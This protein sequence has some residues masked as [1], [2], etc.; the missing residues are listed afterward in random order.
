MLCYDLLSNCILAQLERVV[1]PILQG[2]DLLSNCILAQLREGAA[3]YCPS[4]DLL[5]N[6]ILAQLQER[7]TGVMTV[8][9]YFQIVY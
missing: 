3:A 8:M 7:Y 4:Y 6:C 9:I 2:Y 5:S 1:T